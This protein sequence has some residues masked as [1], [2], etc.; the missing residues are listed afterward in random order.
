ME[1]KLRGMVNDT[2]PL[3]E[4]NTEEIKSLNGRIRDAVNRLPGVSGPAA[5]K[6]ED[7]IRTW[8]E[9]IKELEANKSQNSIEEEALLEIWAKVTRPA[10]YLLAGRA[11][12]KVNV[13]NNPI[14]KE[15]RD[16]YNK[17]SDTRRK[18]A[19][20]LESKRIEL[21]KNLKDQKKIGKVEPKT[22]GEYR[23][24][25]EEALRSEQKSKTYDMRVSKDLRKKRDLE[26]KLSKRGDTFKNDPSRKTKQ[27]QREL[28]DTKN[29]IERVT[30]NTSK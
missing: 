28:R 1:N 13:G 14:D 3:N 19:D 2:F 4:N 27:L 26:Q 5:D 16:V 22:K 25:K 10:R 17:N 24:A 6:L 12:N 7:S 20:E 23:R 11:R 29:N 8:E 18:L 9:R 30:T 15:E 21:K